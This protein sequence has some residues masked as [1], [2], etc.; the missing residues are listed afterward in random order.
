[1][2]VQRIGFT[3]KNHQTSSAQ[4]Q[5]YMTKVN[6]SEGDSF[7]FSDKK[8]GMSFAGNSSG[9]IRQMQKFTKTFEKFFDGI[10]FV[11]NKVCFLSKKEMTKLKIAEIVDNYNKVRQIDYDKV[12]KEAKN[13]NIEKFLKKLLSLK[14][15][16]S[17][18]VSEEGGK[19]VFTRRNQMLIDEYDNLCEKNP[20]MYKSIQQCGLGENGVKIKHNG[21]LHQINPVFSNFHPGQR[22]VLGIISTPI[23]KS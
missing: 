6:D 11:D 5:N 10:E 21:T 22:D 3:H 20:Q 2:Q 13:Q 4:S 12:L 17:F 9:T 7:V 23:P 18:N 16:H 14:A 15:K 8:S 1:M 19:I